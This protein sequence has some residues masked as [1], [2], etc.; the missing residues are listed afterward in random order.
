MCDQCEWVGCQSEQNAPDEWQQ[1]VS[2][3]SGKIYWYNVRS[4]ATQWQ[5]P[6]TATAASAADGRAARQSTSGKASFSS[7]TFFPPVVPLFVSEFALR[8]CQNFFSERGRPAVGAREA[9]SR[10]AF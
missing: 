10:R 9:C 3:T 7:Q 2:K 8:N 4:G 5:P 6:A 1:V